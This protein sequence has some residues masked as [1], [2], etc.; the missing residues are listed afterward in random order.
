M[1]NTSLRYTSLTWLPKETRLTW[2]F[3][4][5]PSS[6]P[7][8]NSFWT[9]ISEEERPQKS[10]T[11]TSFMN[12]NSWIKDTDPISISTE[13]KANGRGYLGIWQAA[14]SCLASS[15]TAHHQPQQVLPLALPRSTWR[16]PWDI[17]GVKEKDQR[18][19]A[20]KF[21][22]TVDRRKTHKQSVVWFL[23]PCEYGVN[24]YT[25]QRCTRTKSRM[26]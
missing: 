12:S 18:N 24:Y 20:S 26:L 9:Q 22:I 10:W 7:I 5:S 13:G 6:F 8:Q 23:L 19:I 25:G 1:C 16:W 15:H 3:V 17:A 14:A 4:F 21:V 2:S 11:P